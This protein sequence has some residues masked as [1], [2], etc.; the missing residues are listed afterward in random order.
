M[1]FGGGEVHSTDDGR[2][3]AVN[4]MSRQH[5]R[6]MLATYPLEWRHR[7]LL[8]CLGGLSGRDVYMQQMVPFGK[9]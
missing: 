2:G 5:L 7:T 4:S 1:A 3:K 6:C 8:Q 9:S